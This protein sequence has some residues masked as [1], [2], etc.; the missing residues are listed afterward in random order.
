MALLVSV[1]AAAEGY[2]VNTLSARQ[3][4]MG[5]TGVA[6]K[7]GAESMYFNPAGM[8]FSDKTLD[9]SVGITGISPTATATIDNVD[10][11]TKNKVSTP[12]YVY[13]G[14]RIYDFLNAGVAFYTPYGSNINWT[15]N[16]PGAVLNQSVKLSTYV[17]QPTL[18]W[19]ILPN[20]SVGAGLTVAWGGV[21]LNKGLVTASSIDL[22]LAASGNPYRFGDITPASVNLKGTADIAVG[23]N[24]GAMWDINDHI[25]I[26]ASFRSKM[27]MKVKA[28]DARVEYANE[29]AAQLLQNKIGLINDANFSAQMPMPYSFTFGVSYKPDSKWIFAFDAQLTGWSAYKQLDIDFLT[30]QLDPFDQHIEKNYKNSWAFR[31]G[32]QYALTER[33]DLRAGFNFDMTP[34][35]KDYYNPETPGMHKLSPSVGFSFRPFSRFSIDLACAYIHG[36]GEDDASCGY[37]DFIYKMNPVLG[38]YNKTIKGSY[39]VHAWAPSIG[40]S[41]SF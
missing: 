39:K 41:Y 13:A 11:Q 26:G 33:F 4:A 12:L 9:L 1:S 8:A 18:S 20:L 16:W 22:L 28:G 23:Y 32:A 21:N 10:Y 2:Q 19:K 38:D 36:V 30:E 7:L 31:L 3:E 15:N 5:H 35:D 37:E 27:Q 25:T 6:L 40:L 24:V 29:I 34:V 17:I 14:F